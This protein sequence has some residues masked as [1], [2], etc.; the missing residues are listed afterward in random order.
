LN[1]GATHSKF[2]LG[3]IVAFFTLG[4]LFSVMQIHQSLDQ[5]QLGYPITYD[6]SSYF[7]DGLVLLHA[8]QDRGPVAFL[9]E[10]LKQPPHSPWSAALAFAGFAIFGAVDWAPAAASS[11]AISL[12]LALLALLTRDLRFHVALLLA[13]GLLT[14]PY[15]GH[16]ICDSRP[17]MAWGIFVALFVAV[18][19]NALGRKLSRREIICAGAL[20]AA[21]LLAK[22]STFPV[23][24]AIAFG[25]I[26]ASVLLQQNKSIADANT[27][28][29]SIGPFALVFVLGFLLALPHYAIAFRTIYEYIAAN[30]FGDRAHIWEL[31]LSLKEHLLYHLTGSGGWA[32]MGAWFWMTAATLA[33][34]LY[35]IYRRRDRPAGARAACY[36][37]AFAIAFAAV[38]I[39]AHKS[40]HI[41]SVVPAICAMAWVAMTVYLARSATTRGRRL[42]SALLIVT[43][44]VGVL[45]FQWHST[46]R[47][48]PADAARFIDIR[49]R[50]NRVTEVLN[51]L[52]THGMSYGKV[53]V[54]GTTLYLNAENLRYYALKSRLDGLAF[55]DD[56]FSDDLRAATTAIDGSDAVI[57]FSADHS[58][59]SRALPSGDAKL[60]GEIAK[61]IEGD[62]HLTRALTLESLD[63]VGETHVFVRRPAFEMGGHARGFGAIEGPYPQWNLTR[64]RWGLG[65]SS[66]FVVPGS[67]HSSRLLLV[68]QTPHKTQVVTVLV[69]GHEVKRHEF[70]G[71]DAPEEIIAGLPDAGGRDRLVELVY[72]KWN[73]GNALDPRKMAV[74]FRR[75]QLE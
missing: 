34:F 26:V 8:V 23:T 4:L 9:S 3:R 17:D 37:V 20:L 30:V 13:V 31:P 47:Y 70:V 51:S 38:T 61:Y 12:V 1:P 45:A 29:R 74:L 27:E 36:A 19:S 64:V 2:P 62:A 63:G 71:T 21:A 11:F 24:L 35:V 7:R 48:G 16:M 33:V 41:G 22:T 40:P 53:Y 42:E 60:V 66:S 50:H 49:E 39:P 69:D 44:V 67:L 43:V 75:I 57:L 14:W 32:M 52:V 59:V 46:I 54:V 73:P 56:L 65:P 5:G 25:V 72:S 55:V 15:F 68:A 10:W 6:D 18:V 28:A 58:E